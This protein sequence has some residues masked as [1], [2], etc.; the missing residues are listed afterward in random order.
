MTTYNPW[1]NIPSEDYEKHMS[2][3]T[4]DQLKALNEIT[5]HQLNK[6]QPESFSLIGCCTGNGLEHIHSSITKRVY[7]VDINPE[8]L[9]ITKIR[10]QKNI[11]SLKLIALDIEKEKLP[12]CDVELTLIALVFEYV[13]LKKAV[14]NIISSIKSKGKVVTVIQR[15]NHQTFVSST[16]FNSLKTLLEISHKVDKHALIK[17]FSVNNF[18]IL[19][20]LVIPLPSGKEFIVITFHKD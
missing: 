5:F 11:P 18:K 19:E 8:Y 3:K 12:F 1:L 7:G 13:N 10:F 20:E 9:K 15:N 6:Y 14:Q 16:K 4:V 17:E 2:D